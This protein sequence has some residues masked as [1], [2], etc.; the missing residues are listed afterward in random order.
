MSLIKNYLK[1]WWMMSKNSFSV[2]LSQRTAMFF[3]LTGKTIRFTFFLGFLYFL[4]L[5]T[6]NLAGYN[7]NQTISFFLVFNLVDVISQFFFRAVYTF[8]SKIVSGDFDLVLV[9]PI[10]SLFTVLLG[11]ADLMDL[12]TIPPLIGVTIYAVGFLHPNFLQIFLFVFLILNALIIAT[13]FHI[14][15]LSFGIITFEIDNVIMIY[16]DLTSLGRFPVDIYRQPIQG[17]LTYLI[18]VGV[19]MTFPAKALMGLVSFQG[20]A[21][22]FFIG[23]VM[24]FL[25]L[26]F[27]NFSLTKYTSASS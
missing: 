21:W 5:G 7:V 14:L 1:I 13:A 9:K 19:M 18:P 3:F 6:K 16:R 11:G 26:R 24:L 20:V 23:V 4:L 2:V 27:W 22:S 10:S 17:I 12:I 25:S 8:R 15:A